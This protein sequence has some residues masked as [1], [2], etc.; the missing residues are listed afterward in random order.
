MSRRNRREVI[1]EILAEY[2]YS[3]WVIIQPNQLNPD[4]NCILCNFTERRI[5]EI[6]I[7]DKWFEDPRRWNAIGE[8]ITLAVDNSG[9]AVSQLAIQQLL[10]LIPGGPICMP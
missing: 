6:A 2:G 10:P 3:D 4:A 8:L 9:S 1:Y 5:T 7:P